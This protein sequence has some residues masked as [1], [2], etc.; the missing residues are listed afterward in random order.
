M[1]P[2]SP[3]SE[4][5]SDQCVLP[6]S[7]SSGTNSNSTSINLQPHE[8]KN[9]TE[10]YLDARK[11]LTNI[12]EGQ[13]CGQKQEKVK[14]RN[15]KDLLLDTLQPYDSFSC[16]SLL[17]SSISPSSLSTTLVSNVEKKDKYS[18]TTVP[19]QIT[20]LK[21]SDIGKKD[22]TNS[23]PVF[24]NSDNNLMA[25]KDI[26]KEEDQ[27]IIMKQNNIM[28]KENIYCL[29]VLSSNTKS[30]KD[31]KTSIDLHQRSPV[32]LSIS[33]SDNSE[34]KTE[35]TCRMWIKPRPARASRTSATNRMSHH[36]R[37]KSKRKKTRSS[38]LPDLMPIDEEGD[39]N[40]I[41]S[42][43]PNNGEVT[44]SNAEE[45]HRLKVK[46]KDKIDERS[47][48]FSSSVQNIF[49]FFG[50]N[51]KNKI[52][53]SI[54]VFPEKSDKEITTASS[55]VVEK[56]RQL[57][58]L[59]NNDANKID[60][61]NDKDNDEL[62][63]PNKLIR[64]KK[65]ENNNDIESST[66]TTTEK[67]VVSSSNSSDATAECS[68]SDVDE[69]IYSRSR[70][71]RATFSYDDGSVASSTNDST[72]AARHASWERLFEKMKRRT[73]INNDNDTTTNTDFWDCNST[74]TGI[75]HNRINRSLSEDCPSV[76]DNDLLENFHSR[77]HNSNPNNTT[78]T[79]KQ[80]STLASLKLAAP[81]ID[82]SVDDDTTT[83]TV[84]T[85]TGLDTSA[86]YCSSLLSNTSNIPTRRT[87]SNVISLLS[88]NDEIRKDPFLNDDNNNTTN[89]PV[90]NKASTKSKK[91]N[92]TDQ[93]KKEINYS[94]LR[95]SNNIETT[96]GKER[97]ALED[98]VVE[99]EKVKG[100]LF[101][102]LFGWFN[103]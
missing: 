101:A 84:T 54:P 7:P 90:T 91:M 40:N 100:R 52:I 20:I 69:R 12:F 41:N 87:H 5:N 45:E 43:Q 6:S 17:V 32:S 66:S 51:K 48:S 92:S 62:H 94:I 38:S 16:Q 3:S 80:D 60:F 4:T 93:R 97:G 28:N 63:G 33:S 57:F 59:P 46:T 88:M 61:K 18:N 73:S 9:N 34:I 19:Q 71:R 55:F 67:K 30:G 75:P 102:N 22:R 86:T 58:S 23:E 44:Q 70:Q 1:L 85:A 79:N 50:I 15:K 98:K 72:Y 95:K 24:F 68:V 99:K 8:L 49:G 103:Q 31:D 82:G 27:R 76:S 65:R 42:Q 64:E 47:C 89:L 26:N 36:T 81:S 96:Y 25:H 14:D 83:S 56:R 74:T 39:K 13:Y 35:E 77:R 53:D 21:K 29:S 37:K 78:I 10:H 11:S 2:P